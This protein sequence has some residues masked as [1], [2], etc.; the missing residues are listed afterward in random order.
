MCLL[1]WVFTAGFLLFV[2]WSVL[3]LYPLGCLVLSACGFTMLDLF[4]KF[5]CFDYRC[6]FRVLL[7]GFGLGGFAVFLRLCGFNWIL[8]LL[9]CV[10]HLFL[11]FWLY[12]FVWIIL[13]GLGLPWVCEFLWL[14]RGIAIFVIYLH[15]LEFVCWDLFKVVIAYWI[16]LLPGWIASLG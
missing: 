14:C 2:W 1:V 5:I 10:S 12:V 11:R 8:Y 13:L 6:V 16:A 3:G 4:P 15:L 9:P 7:L